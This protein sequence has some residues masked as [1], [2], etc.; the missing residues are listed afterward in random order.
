MNIRINSNFQFSVTEISY[1]PNGGLQITLS[2]DENQTASRYQYTACLG[3][4]RAEEKPSVSLLQYCRDYVS[5]ANVKPQTKSSYHLMCRHLQTYG[6][7]PIDKVTTAYLQ[8]FIQYLQLQ[9]LKPGSVHLYFQ[10]LACVLHDAYK[11]QV[12]QNAHFLSS[13]TQ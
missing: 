5:A 8:D 3:N 6:D 7:V 12:S 9:D 4:G 1:A 2:S 11:M 13:K 10:K